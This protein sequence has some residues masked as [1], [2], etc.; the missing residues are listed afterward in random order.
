MPSLS[1]SS[2]RTSGVLSPS[3]SRCTLTST[4]TVTGWSPSWLTVTGIVTVFTSSVPHSAGVKLGVPVICPLSFT[5][6]PCTGLELIV[7]PGLFAVTTTSVFVYGNPSTTGLLG[8]CGSAFSTS[9]TATSTSSLLPSGY[10]TST[11]T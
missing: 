8:L 5:L 7:A 9:S 3:V 10:T 4:F 1:S 11:V 2:S 6:N